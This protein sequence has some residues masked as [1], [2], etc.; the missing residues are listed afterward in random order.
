MIVK[1]LTAVVVGAIIV[2]AATGLVASTSIAAGTARDRATALLTRV[3]LDTDQIN[4]ALQEPGM[5]EI[6]SNVAHPDFKGAKQRFDDFLTQI[7]RT[8]HVASADAA[9]LRSSDEQLRAYQSNLLALPVRSS[10]GRPETRTARMRSAFAE[11]DAAMAIERDQCRALSALMDAMIDLVTM[12]DRFVANDLVGGIAMF[13]G[14]DA[15]LQSAAQLAKT[16]DNPVQIGLLISSLRSSL[17]KI[18]GLLQAAQ[19]N[20]ARTY[21]SLLNQLTGDTQFDALRGQL[22][23]YEQQIYGVHVDI[24]HEDLKAAGFTYP[25]GTRF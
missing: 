21:Q 2:G 10:L 14:V 13:S 4:S 5:S 7:D 9:K 6:T 8:R 18:Q 19:R 16:D 1:I 25:T 11:A 22:A 24:Y 12:G 20:D 17:Q 15:K 3:D 23:F